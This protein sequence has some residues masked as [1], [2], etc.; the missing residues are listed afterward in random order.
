[1]VP[2]TLP[3]TASKWATRVCVPW[4]IYSNSRRLAPLD[5]ARLDRQGGGDPFERL[6]AGHPG[7]ALQS[8]YQSPKLLNEIRILVH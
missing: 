2:P 4:R 5:L 3:V 7:G 6:D 8:V 1:M